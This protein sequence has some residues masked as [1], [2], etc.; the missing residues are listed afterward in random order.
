MN[1]AGTALRL[2]VGWFS[3]LI[4]LL[5]LGVELDRFTGSPDVP[6]LVF[7]GML[8]VGGVLLIYLSSAPVRPGATAALTGGSVLV[9]GFLLSAVPA[10]AAQCCLTTYS[11]QHGYPFAFAARDTGADWTVD[12]L[13]LTADLLFWGYVGLIAL[14][15]L[16]LIQ[17]P[18][19]PPGGTVPARP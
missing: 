14:L 6:Y 19:R 2:L 4:G 13:H 11:Q 1:A 18:G 17:R 15:V 8:L 10:G 3:V 7:H 12:Y 9:A 5:D 16:T